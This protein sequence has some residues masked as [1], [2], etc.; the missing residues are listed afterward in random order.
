MYRKFMRFVGHT[1]SDYNLD[2]PWTRKTEPHCALKRSRTVRGDGAK[3][4]STLLAVECQFH[5]QIKRLNCQ[6][7]DFLPLVIS[8]LL[9]STSRNSIKRYPRRTENPKIST[10]GTVS[11]IH[12]DTCTYSSITVWPSLISSFS[13]NAQHFVDNCFFFGL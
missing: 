8:W 6:Q 12:H 10:V 11:N 9:V 5:V 4:L 3:K 1:S 7:M 13:I 2:E